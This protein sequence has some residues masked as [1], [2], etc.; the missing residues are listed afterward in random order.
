[1]KIDINECYYCKSKN[2]HKV[3]DGFII[4]LDCRAY[5]EPN[6][7]QPIDALSFWIYK[8]EILRKCREE[9]RK[10]IE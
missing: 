8:K 1:M 9:D 10:V 3:E 6:W 2:I 5:V 4:C 7:N